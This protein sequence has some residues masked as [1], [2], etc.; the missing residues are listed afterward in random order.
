[1]PKQRYTLTSYDPVYAVCPEVRIPEEL[2]E[3]QALRWMELNLAKP[4]EK[5]KL[6]D[7]WVNSH[8][9]D[10]K[11]V[12]ELLIFIRYNMYK[13]NREAQE[14]S[15]Q[16]YICRE[17]ATR[18]VEELP[19]DLV[20]ESVYAANMRLEDMISRSG[21]NMQDFCREHGMTIDQLYENTETRAI[22]SLKED[23]A[24]D[25]WADHANFTLEP[26][27]FYAVIPG[28]SVQEKAEKR[29]QI[30]LDGRLAQMEEY[31]LKTKALRDVMENAMIKRNETDTEWL[32][33]GDTNVE[34][35]NAQNQ[36][37]DNFMAL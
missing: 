8:S 15:D 13:D 37:P 31:A 3:K 27:D 35:V 30:E 33:Y 20:E 14:L 7:A 24:L 22:Q 26:E 25:A 34:V 16:D 17:L 11:S 21:M 29:R 9:D 23:S 6:T 28:E 36:Y 12:E 5:A 18:L 1:M 32:R 19:E 2:I 10:F 4:G